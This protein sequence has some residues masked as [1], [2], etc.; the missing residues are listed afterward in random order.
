MCGLVGYVNNKTFE[1]EINYKLVN[2]LVHRGPDDQSS[3]SFNDVGVFFGHTRTSIIDLTSGSQPL[4]TL[5]KDY[6]II[7]NGGIYNFESLK[8]ELISKGYVFSTTS[9]TEEYFLNPTLRWG[10]DVSQ[11]LNGDFAFAIF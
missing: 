10:E 6:T 1:N 9:D 2:S 5:N 3:V 8:E 11:K 4:S 7:F